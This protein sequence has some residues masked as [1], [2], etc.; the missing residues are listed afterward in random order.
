MTIWRTWSSARKRLQQDKYSANNFRMLQLPVP[1]S[2][3]HT[4]G[5]KLIY[6]SVMLVS[7][8][9]GLRVAQKHAYFHGRRTLYFMA[10][11][12]A[13]WDLMGRFCIRSNSI[14]SSLFFVFC[15]CLASLLLF[16][17]F[18]PFKLHLYLLGTAASSSRPSS[19]SS[20]LT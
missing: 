5:R 4:N 1:R 14:L 10:W 7:R 9:Q 19:T 15:M 3:S 18:R 11:H 17:L 6:K 16:L 2:C 13:G 12:A 8:T 20:Q